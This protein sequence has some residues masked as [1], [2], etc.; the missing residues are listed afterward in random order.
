MHLGL[1]AA[2]LAAIVLLSGCRHAQEEISLPPE[3]LVCPAAITWPTTPSGSEVVCPEPEE[4]QA[5]TV[6]D[7][8]L[9]Y[10]G[11]YAR[12]HTVLNARKACLVRIQE[13][14]E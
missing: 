13:M 9:G 6:R 5:G 10:A 4:V 14:K 3:V 12:L 11:C 8:F 2:G 1:R 7:A